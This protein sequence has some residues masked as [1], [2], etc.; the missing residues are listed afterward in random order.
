MS[1]TPA[2]LDA[3]R[4]IV[5]SELDQRSEGIGKVLAGWIELEIAKLGPI[6]TDAL[7]V[8]TLELEKLRKAAADESRDV[9]RA[10][11]R[12]E[13]KIEPL[14]GR[15]GGVETRLKSI[16]DLLQN[17]THAQGVDLQQGASIRN[18]LMPGEKPALSDPP[19]A[20]TGELPTETDNPDVST[21]E[22]DAE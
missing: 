1:L 6:V 22:P 9:S 15:I 14:G 17:L 2:D 8:A 13:G 19:R 12:V 16:E 4:A 20:F 7:G 10:L 5:V 11:G 3:I 21:Q 18:T